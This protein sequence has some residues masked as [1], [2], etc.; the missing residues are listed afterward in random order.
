MIIW[1]CITFLDGLLNALLWIIKC[2]SSYGEQSLWVEGRQERE[3]MPVGG[4][5]GKGK[6]KGGERTD[7]ECG[8]LQQ[9]VLCFETP[10]RHSFTTA[11]I[12]ASVYIYSQYRTIYI[13]KVKII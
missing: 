5:E 3:E 8:W 7:R 9:T 1:R 6:T 2:V 12:S 10:S 11:N 13:Y 4:A